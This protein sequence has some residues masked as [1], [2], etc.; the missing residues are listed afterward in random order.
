[1]TIDLF[2]VG[3]ALDAEDKEYQELKRARAKALAK[4]GKKSE[5]IE[6]ANNAQ[7]SHSPQ[8]AQ[9]SNSQT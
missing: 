6:G 1:M 9:K 8:E 3:D 2:G 7:E 4:W 5:V